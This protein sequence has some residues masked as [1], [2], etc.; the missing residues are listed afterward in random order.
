MT[1]A[2]DLEDRLR[3]GFRAAA[4]A[5]PAAPDAV[6]APGEPVVRFRRSTV[7]GVTGRSLLRRRP[8][9]VGLATAAALA[10]LAGT[11]AVMTGDEP[12]ADAEADVAASSEETTTTT[13]P[14]HEERQVN[15]MVPGRAVGGDGVLH[16]FGADGAPAGTV[17]VSPLGFV[18]SATSDLE[19]GWVVC[20]GVYKTP[21]EI[22]ATLSPE[23]RAEVE[24]LEDDLAGGRRAE[25]RPSTEADPPSTDPDGPSTTPTFTLEVEEEVRVGGVVSVMMWFPAGGE[26]VELDGNVA[27]PGCMDST[28][29]VIDS[30]EG[31]VAMIGGV[32]FGEGSDMT[33]RLEG[34][35]LATGERREVPVPPLPGLPMQWSMSTGRLLIYVEGTGLRLYDLTT[36]EELP[37]AAI[38]PGDASDLALS[39]D[40]RTAAVLKGAIDGPDDAIVYDLATGEEIYRRSFDMSTEGDQMSYDGT[41]LAVG[42]HDNQG[43]DLPVTVIDVATGAEH[44]IDASGMVM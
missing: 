4:E 3:Q 41:T 35:L 44:T 38:D 16:L 36:A 10:A 28:V 39:H 23:T 43:V 34:I 18:D 37:I 25:D 15:G 40:G 17:D 9:L 6:P 1:A 19:G 27:Y 42:G 32:S 26:P 30:P 21:E 12:D 20:G 2:P 7:D 8:V 24:A 14:P 22:D 29:Q 11:A 5:L 33:P 13:A 31:P